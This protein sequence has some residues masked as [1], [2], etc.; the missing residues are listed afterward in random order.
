LR[1]YFFGSAIKDE[2]FEIVSLIAMLYPGPI[3]WRAFSDEEIRLSDFPHYCR[4]DFLVFN[5]NKFAFLFA[6]FLRDEPI[7]PTKLVLYS[8]VMESEMYNFTR[9][10]NYGIFDYVISKGH[11]MSGCHTWK[12]VIQGI[13]KRG[14]RDK[15]R[16]VEYLLY[17]WSRMSFPPLSHF[18]I[19]VREGGY[20]YWGEDRKSYHLAETAFESVWKEEIRE[21]VDGMEITPIWGRPMR[22]VM[23]KNSCFVL[24]PFHDPFNT[25]Y[26]DHI[27]PVL[28]RMDILVERASDYF[29]TREIMKD[30]WDALNN[31]DFVIA[32]L[33]GRNPNVLYE[34][35]IAH[36][37]GKEV[38]MISQKEEDIPFDLRHLRCYFYEYTPRGCNNLSENLRKAAKEIFKKR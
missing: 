23:E 18:E 12:N 34:L 14:R 24:M 7:Y 29:T 36:T 20:T 31:C 5:W 21:E 4:S 13:D 27:M 10:M 9:I 11:T 35:G 38:I 2:A 30:I 26:L 8:G 37:L 28:K 15:I 33:T 16:A 17:R 3:K 6:L 19:K 22:K 1:I 25:I 32:D